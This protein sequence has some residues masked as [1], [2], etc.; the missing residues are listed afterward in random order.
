MIPNITNPPKLIGPWA[1][2]AMGF[3]ESESLDSSISKGEDDISWSNL[4]HSFIEV[5][6]LAITGFLGTP[7]ISAAELLAERLIMINPPVSHWSLCF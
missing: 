4:S 6:S 7:N 3:C 1:R 5:I 2:I